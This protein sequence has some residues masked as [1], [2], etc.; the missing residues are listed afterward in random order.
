MKKQLRHDFQKWIVQK[1]YWMILG[2]VLLFSLGY[3]VYLVQKG[4]PG[5]VVMELGLSQLRPLYWLLCCFM[6]GDV[7]SSDYHYKTMKTT[8]PSSS[9]RTAYLIS[10]SVTSVVICLLLLFAH[11]TS[12]FIVVYMFSPQIEWGLLGELFASAAI[13]AFITVIFLV[14]L[15]TLCMILTENEAATIGF[16]MGTIFIMLVLE[17]L[18]QLAIYI[19]TMQMITLSSTLHSSLTTG[20][21][22]IGA[23]LLSGILFIWSSISIFRSKDLFI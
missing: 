23:L 18:K 10:K 13:G 16:S 7:I 5:M 8:I 20:M 19:P 4:L 6:I 14:G 22:I 17:S 15:I 12:S 9:T 2:G 11:M 3:A 1:R 21:T